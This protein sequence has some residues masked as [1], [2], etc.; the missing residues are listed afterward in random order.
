M[1]VLDASVVV[2]FH[3]TRDVHHVAAAALMER[4][5]AGDYG[6]ALL[7]EYVFLEVVTVIAARRTPA[8]AIAVGEALLSA[9]ELEV[10]PCSEHFPA[11]MATFRQV[12]SFGLSF[13]DAAIVAIARARGTS[14]IATFDRGF[15]R[16]KDLDILPAARGGAR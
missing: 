10:V 5:L 14:T 16:V 7:P 4:M 9:R 6:T 11:T 12:A 3:N 15:A 8:A 2:A 13:A 1:I